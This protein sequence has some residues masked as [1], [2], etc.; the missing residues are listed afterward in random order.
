MP[1]SQ[2]HTYILYLWNGEFIALDNGENISKMTNFLLLM[3]GFN[4]KQS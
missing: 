4:N 3:W 2:N 1:Q